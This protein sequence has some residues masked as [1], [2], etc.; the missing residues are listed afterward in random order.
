MCCAVSGNHNSLCAIGSST[1]ENLVHFHYTLSPLRDI[2]LQ[3]HCILLHLRNTLLFR[4]PLVHIAEFL[5]R[6]NIDM[7]TW[8]W[9]QEQGL[10]RIAPRHFL[11]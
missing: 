4:P 7:R 11:F 8:I 6:A 9:T 10:P 2:L 5:S 1:N 3:F